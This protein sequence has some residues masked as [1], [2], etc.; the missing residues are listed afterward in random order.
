LDNNKGPIKNASLQIAGPF[1]Y[2]AGHVNPNKAG[3]PGLVYDLSVRDYNEFLCGLNYSSTQIKAITG[4]TFPCPARPSKIYNLNYP[5]ITVSE[6]KGSVIVRRIVTNV[7]EGP[8]TYK[9]KVQ[10]PDG[11]LVSVEPEEL[12]FSNI[13]EKKSFIVALKAT[14]SSG[15][16]YV[17]GSLTWKH[18]RNSVVSP[19]VVKVSRQH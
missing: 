3:N 9:A 8:A 10:S 5:S 14:Q 11:V 1:N 12:Q 13:G 7:A 18:D 17:F 6:L 16:Q 15:G 19:I 2:G 4:K